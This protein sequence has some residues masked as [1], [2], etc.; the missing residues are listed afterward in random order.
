MIIVRHI[1]DADMTFFVGIWRKGSYSS[2]KESGKVG[3]HV[4]C[5]I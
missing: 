2:A 1:E 4:Q 3:Y 5:W